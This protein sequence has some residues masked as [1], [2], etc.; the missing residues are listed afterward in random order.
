M[1]GFL[2][3]CLDILSSGPAG[4]LRSNLVA[5]CALGHLHAGDIEHPP[6]GHNHGLDYDDKDDGV[7]HTYLLN[8]KEGEQLGK[9]DTFWSGFCTRRRKNDTTQ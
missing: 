7:E 5:R 3:N 9:G 6:A 4:D 2:L 1:C 8:L